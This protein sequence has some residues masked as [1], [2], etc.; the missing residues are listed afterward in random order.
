MCAMTVFGVR[1]AY[2]SVGSKLLYVRWC[3]VW[4]VYCSASVAPSVL[5][6][7][8]RTW[9][10]S[11]SRNAGAEFSPDAGYSTDSVNAMCSPVTKACDL[12]DKGGVLC[13]VWRNS[14]M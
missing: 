9:S 13:L 8:Q 4:R 6:H 3:A 2:C 7:V 11:D 5:Y 1:V 12:H 10:A 14:E